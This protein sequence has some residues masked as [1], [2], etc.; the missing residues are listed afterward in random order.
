ME[1][2]MPF[3]SHWF[4]QTVLG[5]GPWHFSD[6]GIAIHEAGHAVAAHELGLSIHSVSV[7][8]DGGRFEQ[9]EPT[10]WLRDDQNKARFREAVLASVGPADRWKLYP[11]I[12]LSFAGRAAGRRLGDDGS[13]AEHDVEQA[14]A[15]ASSVT[16]TWAEQSALLYMAERHAE[17]IVRNRWEDIERLA[18]LLVRQ[19]ELNAT[20]IA[21]AVK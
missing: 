6:Y 20:E 16:E 15:I 2:Q 10:E 5:R 1:R 9:F 11:Q 14:R 19:G 17:D 18:D 21:A 13:G 7:T 12:V 3:I 8:P 4:D